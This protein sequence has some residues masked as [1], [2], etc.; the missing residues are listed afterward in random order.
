MLARIESPLARYIVRRLAWTALLL[1]IVSFLTFLVFYVLPAT[2]P[3]LLRAG[4][5]ASPEQIEEVRANLGLDEPFYEQ[6]WIYATNV[7]TD[8]DFGYSYYAEVPVREEIV[9]RLPASISV[10]LGAF[11]LWMAIA[12]PVGILTALKPRSKSDRVVTG[13]TLVLPL[14]TDVLA[15]PRCALPL[16]RG[17]RAVSAHRRSGHVR[18]RSATT[19]ARGSSRCSGPGSSSHSAS[20]GSTRG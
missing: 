6:F 12:L 3:A 13:T 14:G 18:A 15:R 9:S 20:R 7:V 2:D 1:V 19:R 17:H 16:R 10:A 4:R 11:I 5:N 8:L